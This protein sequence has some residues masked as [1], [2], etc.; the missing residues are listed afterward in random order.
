MVGFGFAGLCRR[1]LLYPSDMIWPSVLQTSTFLNTMHRNRNAPAGKWRISRYKLFFI[2]MGAMF[3]YGFLPHAFPVMSRMD[4]LP[5]IWPKSKIVNCLFGVKNG[6]ALLSFTM[7]Y[8]TAIAFLGKRYRYNLTI[9]IPPNCS[10]YCS[11]QYLCRCHILVL[12][13]GRDSLQTESL[14]ESILPNRIVCDFLI[15]LM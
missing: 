6:L 15:S 5:M 13:G 4:V 3:V 14:V 9:R 11:S 8:Q 10:F 2:A 12:F 7:S 1:F